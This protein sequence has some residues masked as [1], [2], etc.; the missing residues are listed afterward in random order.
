MLMTN[1]S[2]FVVNFCKQVPVGYTAISNFRAKKPANKLNVNAQIIIE[3]MRI[4]DGIV[5]GEISNFLTRN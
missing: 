1:L 4:L 3:L 5:K 2:F